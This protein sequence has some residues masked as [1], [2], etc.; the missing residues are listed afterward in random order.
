MITVHVTFKL[1]K[2]LSLDNAKALFLSSAKN[3][4]G[5][6]GLIRKY[7]LLSENGKVAGG[8]YLWDSKKNSKAMYTKEWKA[9]IY[10]KYGVEPTVTYYDSPV[11]VDNLTD[12]II[13]S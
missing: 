5:I 12:E 9:F 11:I 4:R 3:Y 6:T 8:I 10:E 1:K 13:A 2:T 7:Y